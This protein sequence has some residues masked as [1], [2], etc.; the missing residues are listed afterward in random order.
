MA[1]TQD[2]LSD[3][4]QRGQ[5]IFVKAFESWTETI[6]DYTANVG[7]GHFGLPTADHLVNDVFD[8]AEEVLRAQREVA[9][10][11]LNAGSKVSEATKKV[12][13]QAAAE[14]QAA[15]EKVTEEVKAAGAKVSRH[16]AGE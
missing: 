2:Q 6:Q 10:S 13:E 4:T 7:N 8:F 9:T 3:L 16:P 14:A 1:T 12:T 5:Q 11:L 15:A